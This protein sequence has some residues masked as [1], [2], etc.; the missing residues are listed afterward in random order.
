MLSLTTM[1]Q[2]GSCE[3][4]RH[5]PRR[6]STT[7]PP[8]YSPTTSM[9][10]PHNKCSLTPYGRSFAKSPEKIYS[11]T[12]S[13]SPSPN[14]NTNSTNSYHTLS[15]EVDGH[16]SPSHHKTCTTSPPSRSSINKLWTQTSPPTT[17]HKI[18][19]SPFLKSTGQQTP[20]PTNLAETAIFGLHT[21]S[22]ESNNHQQQS[23]P[24]S[25]ST[26][27]TAKAFTDSSS[28]PQASPEHPSNLPEKSKFTTTS[29]LH[30]LANDAS[31]T[32]H[33]PIPL[34]QMRT[35]SSHTRPP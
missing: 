3:V 12:T 8:T 11:S 16:F 4:Y 19:T 10:G 33:N 15:P 5:S 35:P 18:H 7:T 21:T 31:L 34:L 27:H 9:T 25:S 28:T 14:S 32:S 26:Q 23:F 30:P 17:N 6:I 13:P 24:I 20:N 22:P 29:H 2:R 1:D